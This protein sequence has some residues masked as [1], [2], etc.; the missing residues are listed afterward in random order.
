MSLSH[1]ALR[2]E[3]VATARRMNTAIGNPGTSGNVSA[4]AGKGF[5]VTPSGFP[6]DEMTPRDVVAMDFEGKA[7]G[8]HEPSTEWP[9]H[10]AI[11]TARPEV[12]AIVHLHSPAATA[13]AC[14]RRDL[15]PFHYMVAI[16]GGDSVRCAPYATFGTD[17]LARHAVTALEGRTACLLANHGQIAVGPTLARAFAVAAEIEH[18]CGVYLRARAVGE[19]VLLSAAEMA[20]ALAKFATYGRRI[21][22]PRARRSRAR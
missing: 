18:L 11:L 5:L 7:V 14:L 13:V 19:P 10:A 20:E 12:G 22:A 9:F 17:A 4:R 6:Y 2:R 16:A 3:I 1:L 15:P 21:P 8:R